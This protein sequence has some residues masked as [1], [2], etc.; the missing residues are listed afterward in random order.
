[1]SCSSNLSDTRLAVKND[2]ATRKLRRVSNSIWPT[3]Q[4]IPPVSN[5][6]IHSSGTE[7]SLVLKNIERAGTS[8]TQRYLPLRSLLITMP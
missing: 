7:L 3:F 8:F 2:E 5:I 1:M 4:Q 6:S